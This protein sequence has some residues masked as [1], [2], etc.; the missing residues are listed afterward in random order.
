MNL[1]QLG[2][3]IGTEAVAIASAVVRG[4][5]LT[6]S[7]AIGGLFL[8]DLSCLLDLFGVPLVLI[9]AGVAAGVLGCVLAWVRALRP[10]LRRILTVVYFAGVAGFLTALAQHHMAA[11]VVMLALVGAVSIA[12]TVNEIVRFRA[13]QRGCF[14]SPS[15][16]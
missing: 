3:R 15:L 1:R 5:T 2:H 12:L 8:I 14:P 6:I 13:Q 4:D 16:A 7:A 11:A 9:D 10:D